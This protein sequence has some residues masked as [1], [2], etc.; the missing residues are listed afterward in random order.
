[1][2]N[3]KVNGEGI[4]ML[5]LTFTGNNMVQKRVPFV[6]SKLEERLLIG[7]NTLNAR[8]LNVGSNGKEFILQKF[9]DNQSQKPLC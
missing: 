2:N 6:V 5:N 7:S 9:V 3:N 1:M 8:K 4:V